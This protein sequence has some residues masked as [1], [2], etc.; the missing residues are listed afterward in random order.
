[1]PDA[2]PLVSEM[3]AVTA[4]PEAP[5]LDSPERFTNSEKANR[6]L[7]YRYRSP[8]KTPEPRVQKSGSV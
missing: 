6:S 1:M 7:S 5:A 2:A 3:E 8:Y 4:T